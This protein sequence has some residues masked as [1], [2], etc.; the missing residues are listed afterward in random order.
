MTSVIN[1]SKQ[2]VG[3]LWLNRLFCQQGLRLTDGRA[4][5][6]ISPGA[7]SDLQGLYPEFSFAAIR[8]PDS[9][10]TLHGG[11]KIDS[12]SSHWRQQKTLTHPA[13][14]SVILHVVL[15][16]DL[17]LFTNDHLIPTLILKPDQRIE[18]LYQDLR[19]G[20]L[21][22][23]AFTGMDSLHQRQILTRI[24]SDRLARKADEVRAIY[25][26]VGDNWLEASY[27]AFVRSFG[28]REKK[29]SFESLARTTPYRLIR[30]QGNDRISIEALLLGQAGYLDVANADPYT[31][32]LQ[33]RYAVQRR[34]QIMPTPIASF[35]G[36]TVRP[37]SMA[38]QLIVRIAAILARE[39]SLMRRV[40]EAENYNEIFS[41]FDLA[42]DRYWQQNYAPSMP[43]TVN[44]YGISS[45]K[46]DLLIINFVIPLMVDYARSTGNDTLH[47][48]ALELY[49][50]IKPENNTFTRHWTRGGFA[51]ENAFFSQALIQLSTAYCSNGSCGACPLGAHQLRE[52]F[53]S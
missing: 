33:K 26:S 36:S 24:M 8:F 9:D 5:E 52:C 47:E 7:P 46:I 30:M 34:A 1:H 19:R 21:C 40:L 39:E 15:E 3:T 45:E 13:F 2:F 11:I 49:E 42:I 28:Y 27:I 10:V 12:H 50:S 14:D 44:S 6:I 23:D 22:V 16:Q 35:R 18:T 53:F 37:Q 31:V 20:G 32:E 29:D 4:I 17:E 43:A 51:C 48:R 38:P 41:I 25:H